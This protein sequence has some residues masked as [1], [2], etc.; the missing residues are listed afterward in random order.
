KFDE[1]CRAI[2]SG[3]WDNAYDILNQIPHD[4][5]PSE[6]TDAIGTMSD[7]LDPANSTDEKADMIVQFLPG[8]F[9]HA[10]DDE[11]GW[12]NDAMR[13]LVDVQRDFP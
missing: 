9:F 4:G 13:E 1:A 10:Y 6:L 2:E 3:E 8:S 11:H 7:I 5:L 12:D